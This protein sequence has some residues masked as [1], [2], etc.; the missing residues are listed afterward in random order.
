MKRFV[1]GIDRA[2]STLFPEC[3]EGRIGEGNPVRVIDVLLMNSIWRSLD[4]AGSSP[5]PLAVLRI[6]HRC[7]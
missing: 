2:Q 1:D 7:C 4:L 5:R 6:I 3:L